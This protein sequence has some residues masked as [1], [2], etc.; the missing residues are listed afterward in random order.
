MMEAEMSGDLSMV[1]FLKLVGA[2][3]GQ[4]G[5]TVTALRHPKYMLLTPTQPNNF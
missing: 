1:G 2:V 5:I 4:L 3:T